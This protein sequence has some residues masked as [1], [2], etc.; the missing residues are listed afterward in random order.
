MA[1]TKI[2]EVKSVVY[3][4]STNVLP[5]ID[6]MV[7]KVLVQKKVS[8]D[9]KSVENI[10]L[11]QYNAIRYFNSIDEYTALIFGSIPIEEV[12][13]LKEFADFIVP[14]AIRFDPTDLRAKNLAL[15]DG[16]SE[17]PMT[18]IE[19]VNSC[20]AL[21]G[22]FKKDAM[23]DNVSLKDLK[24]PVALSSM[25]HKVSNIIGKTRMVNY[26]EQI[27]YP[28]R[29]EDV[30][31]LWEKRHFNATEENLMNDYLAKFRF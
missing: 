17:A 10:L 19:Y 29:I 31:V 1:E 30:S 15:K 4:G 5:S 11:Q 28:I 18:Y 26:G 22:L 2:G 12:K 27:Y 20:D 9:A 23:S 25:M 6:V 8:C 21:R 3:D 7:S 16:L 13:V 14:S 24:A